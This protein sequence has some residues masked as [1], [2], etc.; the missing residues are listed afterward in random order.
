M[1]N[2]PSQQ[3]VK[4]T[5][6]P[7]YFLPFSAVG[8]CALIWGLLVL[9]DWFAPF[10]DHST[11]EHAKWIF[12]EQ[13]M[14]LQNDQPE[15][16][17]RVMDWIL[18]VSQSCAAI[19]DHTFE[20][21]LTIL[22][23]YWQGA[24]YTSLALFS[25]VALLMMSWPLFALACFLG[26]VDGL[27]SRQRRTAFFGRETETIHYYSQKAVPIVVIATGYGWLFLPGLWPVSPSWM[28][29]PGVML[30]GILVRTCVA[31]YK[32]YV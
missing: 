6:T 7:W 13:L 28:L 26:F 19:L 11:G 10:S 4:D 31:S 21:S 15:L 2:K 9:C 20:H 1:S 3:P 27:V 30:T 25:R 12:T 22:Q 14:L 18:R 29:L 16:A 23:P 8:H 5:P 24:V 17:S 32:K